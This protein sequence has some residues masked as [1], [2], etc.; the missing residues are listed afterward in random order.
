[1]KYNKSWH[2]LRKPDKPV[3]LLLKGVQT[4]Y[5]PRTNH[6]LNPVQITIFVWILI[7]P[8]IRLLYTLCT[9]FVRAFIE[10]VHPLH[11]FSMS[12]RYY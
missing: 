7:R 11:T 1:M 2:T 5:K 3:L 10:N 6:D 9:G 8:L 12:S 4:L